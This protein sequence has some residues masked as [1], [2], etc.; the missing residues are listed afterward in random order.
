[1]EIKIG[2]SARQCAAS[3]KTFEHGDTVYSLIRYQNQEVVREDYVSEHWHPERTKGALAVW[4]TTYHDPKVAEQEPEESYSPLRRLFYEAVESNDRIQL[5]TA[6]LAAQL[7]K[8]QKVFRQI[9]ESALNDT[10]EASRVTLYTDRIGNRLIEVRDPLLTFEELDEGRKRLI[11]R[12]AE[13]EGT[14][15]LENSTTGEEDVN[16]NPTDVDTTHEQAGISN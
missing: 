13:V 15:V 4:S 11:E 14:N 12:L 1:M 2:K 8:R 9:R 7:L 10:S 6:F 16:T 3:A 5:A